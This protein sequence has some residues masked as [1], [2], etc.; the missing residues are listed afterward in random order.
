MAENIA[1]LVSPDGKRSWQPADRAEAVNLRAQGWKPEAKA[2]PKP[3]PKPE[4]K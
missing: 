4:S 1:K 2:V 3:A